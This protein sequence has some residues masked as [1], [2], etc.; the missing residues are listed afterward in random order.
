MCRVPTVLVATVI[1]A[2]LA[3][4]GDSSGPEAVTVTGSWNASITN[5][6]GGGASCNFSNVRAD[7]QQTGNTFVGTYSGGTV[8]CSGQ[9]GTFS[10]LL[11]PGSV[12]NGTVNGNAV[13]FDIDTPDFHL[14]GTINGGSMAGTARLVLDFGAPIGS[15][16]MNGN[17][18]AAKI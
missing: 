14:V 9:G 1:L 12:I 17:W 16:V 18:A 7:L 3:C 5:L 4:G 13:A 10:D 8:S 2:S 11:D 15:I 6:S